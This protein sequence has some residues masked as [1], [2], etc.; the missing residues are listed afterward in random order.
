MGPLEKTIY[1]TVSRE[2]QA[3]RG[4]YDI[5]VPILAGGLATMPG[6]SNLLGYGLGAVDMAV[7]SPSVKHWVTRNLIYQMYNETY[8]PG[9]SSSNRGSSGFGSGGFGSGGFGSKG[10]AFN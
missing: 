10:G 6:V 8:R 5:L 1:N 2:Y 9:Q 3:V 7:T 4:I